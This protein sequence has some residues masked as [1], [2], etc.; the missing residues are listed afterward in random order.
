MTGSSGRHACCRNQATEAYMYPSL[1]R[2]MTPSNTTGVASNRTLSRHKECAVRQHTR[3]SAP[4]EK[5]TLRLEC[6]HCCCLVTS[7]RT[8]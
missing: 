6:K 4:H 3:T 8:L 2:T 5:N 7:L 1:T